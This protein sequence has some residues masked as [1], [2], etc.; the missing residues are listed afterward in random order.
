[1]HQADRGVIAFRVRWS[2]PPSLSGVS[3]VFEIYIGDR[4]VHMNMNACDFPS[5]ITLFSIRSAQIISPDSPLLQPESF[6]KLEKKN[7]V[8]IPSCA[9]TLHP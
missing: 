1:M 4:L 8:Q 6:S 9:S 2:I 3:E 5:L 7:L